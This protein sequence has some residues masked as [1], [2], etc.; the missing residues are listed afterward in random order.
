MIPIA[1]VSSIDVITVCEHRSKVALALSTNIMMIIMVFCT[2]IKWDIFCGSP[3]KVIPAVSLNGLNLPQ[4]NPQP[5]RDHVTRGN[6]GTQKRWNPKDQNLRPVRV[7]RRKP[8][9][10]CILVMNPMNLLEPPFTM[11]KSVHPVVC[12]VLNYKVNHQL[13]YNFTH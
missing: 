8:D 9:R 4:S 12:I 13:R 5:E 10:R 2:T 1:L 7:R 11:Q 6:G 3:R